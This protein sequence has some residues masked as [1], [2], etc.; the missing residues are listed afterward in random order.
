MKKFLLIFLFAVCCIS[1]FC[2]CEANEEE[3]KSTVNNA[4]SNTV[5]GSDAANAS[6]TVKETKNEETKKDY[7]SIDIELLF[8][9]SDTIAL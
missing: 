1:L 2:S 3:G 9:E 7:K 5:I 6:D 4:E 8:T